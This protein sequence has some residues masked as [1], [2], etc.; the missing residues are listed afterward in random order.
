MSILQNE[1]LNTH[2][3]W[4]FLKEGLIK[5]NIIMSSAH[6]I[7]YALC[8]KVTEWH[9]WMYEWMEISVLCAMQKMWKCAM[10]LQNRKWK[11]AF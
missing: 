8:L 10:I 6:V 7:Y 11:Y 1:G 2:K 4:I 9:T 3:I 5:K